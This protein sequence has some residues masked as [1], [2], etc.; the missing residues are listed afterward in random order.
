MQRL[1]HGDVLPMAMSAFK[2]ANPGAVLEDFVA[3]LRNHQDSTETEGCTSRQTLSQGDQGQG[4]GE[5]RGQAHP[6]GA[7]AKGNPHGNTTSNNLRQA[8]A[9]ADCNSSCGGADP[10]A[11]LKVMLGHVNSRPHAEHTATGVGGVDGVGAPAEQRD[12]DGVGAAADERG[13]DGVAAGVDG[14]G[15]G[16]SDVTGLQGVPEAWQSTWAA[17]AA[18]P[19]WEQ[20]PLQVRGRDDC[21]G[22]DV[23]NSPWGL[24]EAEGSG[25]RNSC[26][27]Q[28]A[29]GVPAWEQKPL[30]VRG[31]GSWTGDSNL[32]GRRALHA[33]ET[34]LLLL[35]SA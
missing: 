31:F 11:R 15:D 34:V 4:S 29:V 14:G 3:W 1:V 21:D 2:A 13:V 28:K 35:V 8:G 25:L 17:A 9:V 32:E 12:V 10:V 23:F 5:K 27:L 33:L 6:L 24:V 30:Q 16:A 19:A 26:C 22:G 7:L 20:K 18:V